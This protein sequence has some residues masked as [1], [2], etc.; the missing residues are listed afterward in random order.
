[1]VSKANTQTVEEGLGQLQV[2]DGA[3]GARVLTVAFSQ[4]YRR[5]NFIQTKSW[6]TKGMS[7]E[8]AFPIPQDWDSHFN[9]EFCKQFTSHYK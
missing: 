5:F 6:E 2:E 7:R 4:L 9:N 3:E 8:D 1:M